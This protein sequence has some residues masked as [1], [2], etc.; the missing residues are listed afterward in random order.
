MDEKLA[1]RRAK[2]A[3]AVRRYRAKM[4]DE[5]REAYRAKNRLEA[6]AYVVRKRAK[7]NPEHR[8][9]RAFDPDS[10]FDRHPDEDQGLRIE[11]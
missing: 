2:N 9:Q 10:L 5:E 6:R 11:G 7:L 1:L 4:T 3:E 8:S